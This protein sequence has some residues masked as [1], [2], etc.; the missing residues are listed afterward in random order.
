MKILTVV[1]R[2]Y[3]GLI[4]FILLYKRIFWVFEPLL[5]QANNGPKHSGCSLQISRCFAEQKNWLNQG[6]K[7]E[8]TFNL[9][10]FQ[11]SRMKSKMLPLGKWSTS[12]SRL[13]WETWGGC[14]EAARVLQVK[15]H[16]KYEWPTRS[17]T[18]RKNYKVVCFINMFGV[19]VHDKIIV[20][21]RHL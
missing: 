15:I 2:I 9:I 10:H 20:L 6:C 8:K 7:N 4:V 21:L 12:K 18:F 3:Q 1:S 14:D 16:W 11:S 17:R 13:F 19:Q 5:N